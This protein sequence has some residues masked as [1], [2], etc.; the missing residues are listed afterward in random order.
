MDQK[1]RLKLEPAKVRSIVLQNTANN[2]AFVACIL[3]DEVLDVLVRRLLGMW[4]EYR[5]IRLIFSANPIDVRDGRN[6]VIMS[7]SS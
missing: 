4:Y 2:Q 5:D 1:N 6:S 3:G 7:N